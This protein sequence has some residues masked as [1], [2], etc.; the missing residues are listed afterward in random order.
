MDYDFLVIGAGVVGLAQAEILS[1]NGKRVLVIEKEARIGTGVSSRNSEVI[2]A[3]IYYPKGS[4]KSRLCIRGKELIYDWCRKKNVPHRNV[5][6]YIIAVD[7]TEMEKLEQIRLNASEAGMGD[8][9]T[10]SKK[11]IAKEEPYV[12]SSGGLFSPTTGIISAH[13]LM[14]SL[15]HASEE[16]GC[17]YLF[18]SKLV[19]F[20]K[21]SSS[22]Y[23]AKI[24]DSSGEET[25]I[26]VGGV[27]NSAGLYSDQVAELLGVKNADYRLKMVKGNY[28]R[29]R[30]K[31]EVFRHLIYPVPMPKLHGLGVHVTL[32]LNG[33]VRF[34]PDVEKE[35]LSEEKYFVDESRQGKFYNAI[36]AYF[37]SV[38]YDD[39]YPDMAGIR[40]RLASERDFNDFIINEESAS[41]LPQVINLVGIE[42]PGLTASMAIA[43]YVYTRFIV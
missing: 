28:F 16:R 24:K 39:I 5:G 11:E 29:L 25:E 8:L 35:P 38:R 2:H 43:E 4:L 21:N 15:K 19:A 34:G 14:D 42:S 37:P 7:E 26:E 10:V 22:G 6:K 30:G 41:A 13:G 32:D 3:G 12:F 18:N 40:P 17:D 1:R 31:K 36:K 27:I 20:S 23:L 9:Y 33:G